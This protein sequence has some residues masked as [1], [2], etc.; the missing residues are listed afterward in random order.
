MYSTQSDCNN[1]DDGIYYQ[2]GIDYIN[3][4]GYTEF[5]GYEMCC[6]CGGGTDYPYPYDCQDNE[7]AINFYGGNL[8]HEIGWEI[9]TCDG[10]IFLSGGAPFFDCVELPSEGYQVVVT[11]SGANGWQMDTS[12]G[13][14]GVLQVGD[15]EYGLGT[16]GFR[17]SV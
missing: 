17:I 9:Q 14:Y 13:A 10:S 1:N 6:A 16:L 4:F 3:E 8:Y 11:D 5:V 12:I 15:Q 2:G 7:T